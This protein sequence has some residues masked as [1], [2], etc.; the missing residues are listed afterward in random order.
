MALT[1]LRTFSSAP[2][3]L[4]RH[5]TVSWWT[6]F[7][8][9]FSSLLLAGPLRVCLRSFSVAERCFSLVQESS[10]K[11]HLPNVQVSPKECAPFLCAPKSRVQSRVRSG[12]PSVSTPRGHALGQRCNG[13]LDGF[14]GN[15]GIQALLQGELG[16]LGAE[17]KCRQPK[18]LAPMF[19]EKKKTSPN[20]HESIAV[21][22]CF[23][24]FSE[25][26]TYHHCTCEGALCESFELQRHGAGRFT[27]FFP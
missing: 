22:M 21:V 23:P 19:C 3:R 14:L 15:R 8:T 5:Y 12:R 25:R 4:H 1:C 16:P 11:V 18:A 13:L 27:P 9:S 2:Q 10:P 6:C 20:M 17:V 7:E 26:L 24:I